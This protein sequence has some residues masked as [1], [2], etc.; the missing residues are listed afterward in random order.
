[1][2]LVTASPAIRVALLD[3]AAQDEAFHVLQMAR[4]L[5]FLDGGLAMCETGSAPS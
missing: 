2:L 1:M 3:W 5:R 4:R